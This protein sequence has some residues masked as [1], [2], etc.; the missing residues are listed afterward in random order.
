MDTKEDTSE[1][2]SPKDLEDHKGRS[3]G[4]NHHDVQGL[5]ENSSPA[6]LRYSHT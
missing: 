6:V 3:K 1:T 5:A 2:D 4:A